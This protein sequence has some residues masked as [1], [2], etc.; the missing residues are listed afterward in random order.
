[1]VGAGQVSLRR[2]APRHTTGQSGATS[3][4]IS[5]QDHRVIAGHACRTGLSED[6]MELNENADI[7][8]S[9][10]ED[11]RGSG[12]GGRR[13]LRRPAHPDRRRRP[14]RH[15]R[16]SW[17]SPW[18]AASSASTSWAAA[19]AALRHRRQH[20]PHTGVLGRPTSSSS[21][22]AATCSTSTRSRR[23]GP[24]PSRRPSASV[25]EAHDRVLLQP[26][27]HRL[28]RRRLRHRAVLLPRRRPGVHRPHLL[29]AARRPARRAGRVRPAVRAGP[30]VRPPHPGPG[31]HRGAR[32]AGAQERASSDAEKNLLSVKLELQADCYA[33]VWAK[34][35]TEHHRRPTGR[36]SSRA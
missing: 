20:Q 13:R 5:D 22:T 21:S 6:E 27:D 35:A 34:G 23:S 32:C 31:R 30:R 3:H 24:R 17:C 26:G 36:R 29:P 8:T 19:A 1:M 33:G 16:S 10:V 14:G 12:G 25:P 4:P 7:D 11:Q 15:H 28:R 2:A 18:S 9:Q